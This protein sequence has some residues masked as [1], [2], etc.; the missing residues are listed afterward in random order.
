MGKLSKLIKYHFSYL[1]TK[2][3]ILILIITVALVLFFNLF[4][5]LSFDNRISSDDMI[6]DYYMS[7][8]TIIKLL[9]IL[10]IIFL[11][12][13][14]FIS[15]NDEYRAITITKKINRYFYFISKVVTLSFVYI[16]LGLLLIA[17]TLVIALAFNIVLSKI[18]I[19][20]FFILLVT[21]FYYGF[22]SILLVLLFD[23]VYIIFLVFPLS[24]LK[25]DDS[26]EFLCYFMPINYNNDYTIISTWRFS[27]IY[28]IFINIMLF[29]IIVFIWGKKDLQN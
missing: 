22:I 24:L 5:A 25:Y 23:N 28:Y 11:F 2:A 15:S 9:L 20:S 8:Y 19:E 21:S 3:T 4:T 18:M 13:Y 6:L 16:F 27:I 12:G 17:I 29:I 26:T 7:S 1:F 10:F 14:S